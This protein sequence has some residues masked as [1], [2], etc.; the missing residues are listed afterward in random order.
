MQVTED[1]VFDAVRRELHDRDEWSHRPLTELGSESELEHVFRVLGLVLPAEPLWVALHAVQADDVSLRGTALEYL[2]SILP[3]DVR[4]QL[5]P[6]LDHEHG[7]VLTARTS[8]T[9]D[10]MIAELSGAF[11]LLKTS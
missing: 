4:A 6:L 7:A 11:P 9:R 2:E 8:R 1:D 10:E 5:W 3:A